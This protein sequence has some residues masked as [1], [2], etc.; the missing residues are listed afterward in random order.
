M[1][2]ITQVLSVGRFATPERAEILR[3]MRVTH[4][5]NVSSG[6]SQV[7]AADGGF[8][9]V[10]WEPLEEHS[11]IPAETLV[12][13]L[14]TLHRMATTAG[15]HV[16]VH[17]VAGHLRSPSVLWLYLIA[18]GI[19]P[20]DARNWIERRSPEAAPGLSRMVTEE[21]VQLA[22]RHGFDGFLQHPRGEVLIPFGEP[23]H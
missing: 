5:L 11:P 12:D 20:E 7:S 6:P 13:L 21:H 1:Y 2:R 19:S 8:H 3:A 22:R 9:E 16:Y 10:A 14:D 15:S 23:G 18:C 4:I 17:C